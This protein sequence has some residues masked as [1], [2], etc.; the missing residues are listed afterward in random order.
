MLVTEARRMLRSGAYLVDVLALELLDELVE[1]LAV[2]L[3][4][5]G[6]KDLLDV[7][8]GRRGVAAEAEEKV[9]CEVLHC[10]VGCGCRLRTG[11]QSI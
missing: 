4:A 11:V 8:G 10:D 9:C 3:D 7:A 6:L 2:G 1:A 5:D